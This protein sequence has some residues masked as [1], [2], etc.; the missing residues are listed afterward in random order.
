MKSPVRDGR[1]TAKHTGTYLSRLQR[2]LPRL[3]ETDLVGHQVSEEGL[4]APLLELFIGFP[5]ARE[6]VNRAIHRWF[7]WKEN[8]LRLL[9]DLDSAVMVELK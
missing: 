9:L 3:T 5:P 1:R 7:N 6:S 4:L 8:V 2:R